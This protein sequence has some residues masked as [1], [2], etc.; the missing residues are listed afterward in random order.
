[1]RQCRPSLVARASVP[2]LHSAA[3]GASSN[4]LSIRADIQR[5]EI[6][7]RLNGLSNQLPRTRGLDF[8]D[9]FGPSDR[10]SS[11]GAIEVQRAHSAF[12]I[13]LFPYSGKTGECIKAQHAA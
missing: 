7:P 12:V 9:A 4:E 1:M 3:T 10:H 11:A 2:Q 6:A 13:R 8:D 5:S